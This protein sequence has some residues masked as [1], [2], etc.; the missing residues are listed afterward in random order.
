MAQ[1]AD[2][3]TIL[4]ISSDTQKIIETILELGGQLSLPNVHRDWVIFDGTSGDCFKQWIDQVETIHLESK[5][6]QEIT[7]RAASRLLKG[8]AL[9]AA[10]GDLR[11]IGAPMD[12][13][14]CAPLEVP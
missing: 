6:N 13:C 4:P 9:P 1:S 8:S 12:D 3:P 5:G 10:S 7:F 2:T 14:F 11:L